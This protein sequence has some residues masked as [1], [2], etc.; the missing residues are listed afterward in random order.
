M[1]HQCIRPQTRVL[2]AQ[3]RTYTAKLRANH[4][5]VNRA[6]AKSVLFALCRWLYD[7]KI[8]ATDAETRAFES[9][10]TDSESD[11]HFVSVLHQFAD[12]YFNPTEACDDDPGDWFLP[13]G[14][15][16]DDGALHV[17]DEVQRLLNHV[18]SDRSR[19]CNER[20]KRH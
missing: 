16:G 1:N 20:S 8:L 2:S 11:D 3:I 4:Y 12:S 18:G 7:E 14:G 17:L 6:A 13:G 19:M 5:R 10:E 15:D 9:L